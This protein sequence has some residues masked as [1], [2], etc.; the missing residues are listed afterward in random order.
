[1]DNRK[2]EGGLNRAK[3]GLATGV[4]RAPREDGGEKKGRVAKKKWKGDEKNNK[5]QFCS[6]THGREIS[7]RIKVSGRNEDKREK[8]GG[9]RGPPYP[10]L[11]TGRGKSKKNGGVG[12]KEHGFPK[13]KPGR[14][15]QWGK[16][17]RS[18][19]FEKPG[20]KKNKQTK[21]TCQKK[22]RKEAWHVHYRIRRTPL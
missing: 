20:G 11:T 14:A 22:K 3:P 15:E 18:E 17:D 12:K 5:G 2:R 13:V 1:M 4:L 8:R 9:Q 7:G 16:W 21:R 6:C 19:K 10:R